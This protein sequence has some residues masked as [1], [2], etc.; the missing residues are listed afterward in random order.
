M[1]VL[2]LML[3]V[4]HNLDVKKRFF[5]AVMFGMS[6][7]VTHYGL[8]YLMMLILIMTA[9]FL[10]LLD[11][12]LNKRLSDKIWPKIYR[13]TA[14]T[15]VITGHSQ[16]I[17]KM[18]MSRKAKEPSIVEKIELYR[19]KSSDRIITSAFII[20]FI[21]FLFSWYSYTSSST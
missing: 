19:T 7:V 11:K 5:L 14:V 16:G 1:L 21:F 2:V 9:M 17:K 15:T 6:I 20:L 4:T 18:A 12:D 3:I 8:T 10:Y 13:L